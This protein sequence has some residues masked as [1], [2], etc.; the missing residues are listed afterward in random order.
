MILNE[1]L[2]ARQRIMIAALLVVLSVSDVETVSP[3]VAVAYRE[4]INAL[5]E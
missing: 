2:S 5:A 3:T 4:T 1:P